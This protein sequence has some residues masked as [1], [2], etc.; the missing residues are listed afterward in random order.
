MIKSKGALAIAE[1][2]KEN[3][4]LRVLDL[5]FNNIGVGIEGEKL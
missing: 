1:G 2:I 3:R 4:Y 5:S